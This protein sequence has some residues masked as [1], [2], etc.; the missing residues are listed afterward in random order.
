MQQYPFTVHRE[1]S[2]KDA[3]ATIAGIALALVLTVAVIGG[4]G[5]VAY[6]GVIEPYVFQQ[7]AENVRHTYNYVVGHNEQIRERIAEYEGATDDAHRNA[8]LRDIKALAAQLSR[9]EVD[10]DN[11]AWIAAH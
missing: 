9:E 1:E 3:L 11:A 4:S 5:I 7:H 6:Y 10:T 8:L 2:M